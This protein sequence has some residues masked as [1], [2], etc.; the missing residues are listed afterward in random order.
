MARA[1]AR[2]PCVAAQA[3]EIEG[4]RPFRNGRAPPPPVKSFKNPIPGVAQ[5]KDGSQKVARPTSAD[6]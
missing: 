2:A 4:A 6:W 1:R 5:F 3:R